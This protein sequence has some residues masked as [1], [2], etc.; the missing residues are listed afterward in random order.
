[1]PFEIE[2]DYAQYVDGKPR[3]DGVRS[4]LAARG[5]ALPEGSPADAPEAETVC[6]LGNR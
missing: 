5:I 2:T 6:G 1:V 3:F 4:F